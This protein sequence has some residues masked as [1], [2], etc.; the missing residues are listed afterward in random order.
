M[1]NQCTDS[2]ADASSWANLQNSIHETKTPFGGES[3]FYEFNCLDAAQDVKA[4]IRL[5]IRDWD[6]S[7]RIKDNITELIPA[8]LLMNSTGT[9]PL[10]LSWNNNYDWDDAYHLTSSTVQATSCGALPAGT[11]SAGGHATITL[12]K[13][14]GQTWNDPGYCSRATYLTR[15]T[16]EDAGETWMPTT[17]GS[18]SAGGHTTRAA[19]LGAGNTWTYREFPFPGEEI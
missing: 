6:R 11:C 17:E 15:K 8:S 2:R 5:T 10:G 12:C 9:T 7:F 4:R 19:C 18:C 1:G 13:A 3:P 14:A 16:C